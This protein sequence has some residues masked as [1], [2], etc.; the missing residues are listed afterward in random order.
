[1]QIACLYNFLNLNLPLNLKFLFQV[2][3]DAINLNILPFT[4]PNPF[5][6]TI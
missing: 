6:D 2:L 3:F 4:L 1:M 5:T